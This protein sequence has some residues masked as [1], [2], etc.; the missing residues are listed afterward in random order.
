MEHR[1]QQHV[2]SYLRDIALRD[3]SDEATTQNITLAIDTLCDALSIVPYDCPPSTRLLDLFTSGAESLGASS[4]ALKHGAS[5]KDSDRLKGLGIDAFKKGETRKAIN[6]FI[7]SIEAKETA[8]VHCNLAGCYIKIQDYTTAIRHS[9]AAIKLDPA[10]GKAH[11]RLALASERAGD[12]LD[13]LKHAEKAT[14]LAPDSPT[15]S[16]LAVRLK[17]VVRESTV[18]PGEADCVPAGLT[19]E[20]AAVYGGHPQDATD[21]ST[22]W[23]SLTAN[24]PHLL[25]DVA[26]DPRVALCMKHPMMPAL[27]E[28]VRRAGLPAGLLPFKDVQGLAPLVD[29]FEEQWSRIMKKLEELKLK[30]SARTPKEM[31]HNLYL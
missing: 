4:I 30:P 9:K 11:Y 19:P 18:A 21:A 5:V 15:Y 8:A 17:R 6:L 3:E 20:Q 12:I 16:K 23:E 7:R 27:L 14:S 28:S 1:L 2:I 25:G 22:L 29:L 24:M 31:D 10:Y 26:K 13:A